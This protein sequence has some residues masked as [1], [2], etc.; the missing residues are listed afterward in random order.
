M[1]SPKQIIEA[2]P[3]YRPIAEARRFGINIGV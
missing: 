3:A 2:R 1:N